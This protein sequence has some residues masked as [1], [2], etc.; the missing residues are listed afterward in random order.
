M[1]VYIVMRVRLTLQLWRSLI[2]RFVKDTALGCILDCG[3]GRPRG[4]WRL[5]ISA[6]SNKIIR[7]A[8]AVIDDVQLDLQ[9]QALWYLE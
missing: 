4:G 3:R 9:K 1:P 5:V 6:L 2:S 7:A 8:I